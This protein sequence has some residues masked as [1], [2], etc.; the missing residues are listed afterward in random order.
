MYSERG[1]PNPQVGGGAYAYVI[2]YSTVRLS[3]PDKQSHWESN[4]QRKLE[5]RSCNENGDSKNDPS[6]CSPFLCALVQSD[7]LSNQLSQSEGVSWVPS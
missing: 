1:S 2:C 5:I 6:H 3:K 7:W 4:R